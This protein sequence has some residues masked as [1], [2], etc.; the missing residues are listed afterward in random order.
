MRTLIN[1]F[2]TVSDCE[3]D[4]EVLVK[5]TIKTST[6][7]STPI[8]QFCDRNHRKGLK[9][10]LPSSKGLGIWAF[11][12]TTKAEK[13]RIIQRHTVIGAMGKI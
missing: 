13:D 7:N 4:L 8:Y 5:N 6:K 12:L 1:K 11:S 10:N 3:K 2:L 9:I